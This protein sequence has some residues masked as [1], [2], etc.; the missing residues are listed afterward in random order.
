MALAEN[1]PNVYSAIGVHPNEI[2]KRLSPM[3]KLLLLYHISRTR[4]L[5]PS[6]RLDWIITIMSLIMKSTNKSLLSTIEI[7]LLQIIF[8]LS[9]HSREAIRDVLDIISGCYSKPHQTIP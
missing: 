6:V 8:R 1:Y 9:V 5:L 3:V 4:K 2:D 7:S